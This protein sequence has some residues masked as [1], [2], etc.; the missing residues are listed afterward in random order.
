MLEAG[1]AAKRAGRY[2][3]A[4]T[5]VRN[6]LR[7]QDSLRMA[8][9]LRGG[10]RV[11]LADCLLAQGNRTEAEQMVRDALKLYQERPPEVKGQREQAESL[12]AQLKQ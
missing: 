6:A 10:T 4:E 8:P 1:R 7:V 5:R 2:A 3:D 12:L 9:A 11:E